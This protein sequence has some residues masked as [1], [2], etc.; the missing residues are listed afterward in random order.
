MLSSVDR[1]SVRNIFWS[2][3]FK[4]FWSRVIQTM[5]EATLGKPGQPVTGACHQNSSSL[6]IRMKHSLQC[7]I[8]PRGIIS[9]IMNVLFY[10]LFFDTNTGLS[11]QSAKRITCLASQQMDN[12]LNRRIFVSSSAKAWWY[13]MLEDKASGLFW[14][15]SNDIWDRIFKY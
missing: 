3:N 13:Q 10:C 14:I 9:H 5:V 2:R 7:F 6:P 11:C 15:N 4:L 1:L 12:Q 8:L